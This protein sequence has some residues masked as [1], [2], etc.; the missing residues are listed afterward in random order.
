MSS[1]PYHGRDGS[2]RTWPNS[3][4]AAAL[5]PAPLSPTLTAIF[6]T[7]HIYPQYALMTGSTY[8]QIDLADF[9]RLIGSA[10]EVSSAALGGRVLSVSDEWFAPWVLPRLS[11]ESAALTDS[12]CF[13]NHTVERVTY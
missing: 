12:L 8:T 6:S 2:D 11:L 9:D 5:R 1:R 10:T 3:P 13:S 4:V 7:T